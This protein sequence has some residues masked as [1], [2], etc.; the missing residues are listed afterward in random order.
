MFKWYSINHFSKAL[1][2]VLL[3]CYEVIQEH[4][5]V[6]RLDCSKFWGYSHNRLSCHLTDSSGKDRVDSFWSEVIFTVWSTVGYCVKFVIALSAKVFW[7]VGYMPIST[8]DYLPKYRYSGL[9][10]WR[11]GG[12]TLSNQST[13]LTLPWKR[14]ISDPAL[15]SCRIKCS[16]NGLVLGLAAVVPA[17]WSKIA[18]IQIV[19]C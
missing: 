11:G 1:S 19:H 17:A 4:T 3:V 13:T 12:V 16:V 8:V 7:I 6:N 2:K 10:V 18:G 15:T 14:W 5:A 9:L